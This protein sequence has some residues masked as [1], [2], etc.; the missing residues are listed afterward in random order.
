MI[1][2]TD[3]RVVSLESIK[4]SLKGN[5]LL[6]WLGNFFVNR[7]GSKLHALIT[8]AISN[9]MKQAVEQFVK[10]INQ[11]KNKFPFI[12]LQNIFKLALA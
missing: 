2:M 12:A 9:Q 8:T 5:I 11:N 6:D 7:E 10:K 3:F 1:N 4:I